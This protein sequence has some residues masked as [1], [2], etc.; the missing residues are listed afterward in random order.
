MATLRGDIPYRKATLPAEVAEQ[1]LK[2][3]RSYNLNFSTMDLIV[4]PDDRYVFIENNPN[5]QFMFI[6]K[7]VP[8]LPMTAALAACLIRGANS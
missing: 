4:T 5:G 6:E 3:V 8:E 2:L 1:C 7:R